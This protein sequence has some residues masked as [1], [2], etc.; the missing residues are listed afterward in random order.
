MLKFVSQ[1]RKAS[2]M[3]SVNSDGLPFF[4]N[5]V[6]KW[7]DCFGLP[8]TNSSKP[9]CVRSCSR[10]TGQVKQGLCCRLCA[11]YFP[12]RHYCNVDVI[13]VI[14]DDANE[15]YGLDNTETIFPFLK[16]IQWIS[17]TKDEKYVWMNIRKDT[18]FILSRNVQVAARIRKNIPIY[19]RYVHTAY[20]CLLH[21]TW[22]H[23]CTHAYSTYKKNGEPTCISSLCISDLFGL[24][25]SSDLKE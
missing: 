17:Q 22:M 2:L 4:F 12:C 6:K 21:Y 16:T 8:E 7:S 19:E 1:F 25:L 10:E 5:F 24:F 9:F 20:K 18:F 11:L 3:S 23:T 15:L 13:E 14:S